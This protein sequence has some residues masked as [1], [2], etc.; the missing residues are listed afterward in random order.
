M[1]VDLLGDLG[2]AIGI[3]P[4]IR[5]DV[6]DLDNPVAFEGRGEPWEGDGNLDHFDPDGFDFADIGHEDENGQESEG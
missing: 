4:A 3:H 2:D 1:G 5:M 6:G